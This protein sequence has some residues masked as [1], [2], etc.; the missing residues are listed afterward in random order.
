MNIP[1]LRFAEFSEEYKEFRL[2]DIGEVARGRFTPRPRNDPRFFKGGTIPFIQTGDIV[3]APL[4][5]EQYTQFINDEGVKVSKIFPVDTVFVTIAANIGDVAI[6]KE[7]VACTDSVVGICPNREKINSVWLKYFLDTRK[8]ELDS[9]ASQNAQKNINLQVLKPLKVFLPPLDEQNKVS[10]L[11]LALDNNISTLVN[12]SEFLLTYKKGVMR[13]LFNQDIR[14]K[15]DEGN[16]YPEWTNT[17]IGEIFQD[18]KG[19]LLPKEVVTEEGKN[20]CI[21]YGELFTKYSEVIKNVLSRTESTD[22]T[23]SKCGDLL[24]PSSTTTSAIDLA[25][26]STVLED[27]VLLGGDIIILRPKVPCDSQYMAY[28]M[29]HGIKKELSKNAQGITIIHMYFS[30]IKDVLL[31]VPCVGEQVKIAKFLTAI[32]EK[33]SN[34]QNQLEL[35]KQFKQGLLQQMFV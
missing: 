16:N 14:F 18:L 20:K 28:F 6:A 1:K 9:K 31:K 10:N 33:I 7:A 34:V 3:R 25:I 8:S 22:G 19:T 15:D 17:A 35:T 23:P 5:V 29:T 12:M 4:Y 30:K 32:D 21:L 27:G 26:A 24:M 2:E 13:K 11:L